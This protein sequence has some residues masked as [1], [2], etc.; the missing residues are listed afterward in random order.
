MSD[1]VSRRTVLAAATAGLAAGVVARPAST[2]EPARPRRL[3]AAFVGHGSP[4]TALDAAK[5]GAWTRWAASWPKPKAVLVVSAHWERAPATIGA[6]TTVPLIYDMVGFPEALYRVRYPAPGAPKLADRVQRI[7]GAVGPVRRDEA[8]GLDHGAWVPLRW[9]YPD[10]DV[11]VLPLSLPSQDPRQLV[12]TGRR[13][14][15]LRDEGVLVLGS[16]NLVHNLGR[17]GRDGTPTPSWAKEFDEW[18]AGALA[19]KDVDALVDWQRR[20]PAPRQAHPT[21]EHLNPVL[22]VAGAG[23]DDSAAVRFPITG[24]EGS[25]VSRRCVEVT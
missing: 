19:R 15:P 25:S 16:G 12:T 5:G 24:F 14:A 2:D 17:L 13:L 21:A 9:L 22:V 3:P 11:P 18:C 7:L 23:F 6:T 8:R 20:A 1:G 4:M 10:A